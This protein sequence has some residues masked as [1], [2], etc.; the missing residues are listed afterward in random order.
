MVE[1]AFVI[2]AKIG[3]GSF[4]EVF[5]VR[6]REDGRRFA[7]KRA[8]SKFRSEADRAAKLG[9]VSSVPSLPGKAKRSCGVGVQ[10]QKHEGLP[11]HPNLVGFVRAWEERGRLY[12]QTELCRSSLAAVSEAAHELPEPLL[13]QYLVDL[14]LAV[15]HLHNNG[16]ALP[17]A[18]FD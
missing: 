11:P 9:E 18:S 5:R 10:V 1:Q 13:W 15:Q 6:N 3:E 14:L 2:E 4:G 8:I 7:V 16:P 17:P 12:I